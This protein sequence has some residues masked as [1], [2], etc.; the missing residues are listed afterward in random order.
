[1]MDRLKVEWSHLWPSSFSCKLGGAEIHR[2]ML[3]ALL[4]RGNAF[5]PYATPTK[6]T[7][8]FVKAYKSSLQDI[9]K[10]SGDL[11]QD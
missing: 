4:K 9:L 11:L 3:L 10:Y 7:T 2:R 1:M 5:D 6:E 8:F